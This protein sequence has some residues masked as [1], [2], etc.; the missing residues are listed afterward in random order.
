MNIAL[1]VLQG[2]LAVAFLGAGSMK[3]FASQQALVSRGMDFAER[4]PMGAVRALGLAEVLGAIGVMLPGLVKIAPVL[5]PVA[6]A[7]LAAV[8][9]GAVILHVRRHEGPAVL[10]AAVL[11]VVAVAVAW[12]RSG[13]YAF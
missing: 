11:L 2:V 8:M 6:A 1:W 12:G 10:P 13:P 9:V 3:L 4:V 5:V 7:C